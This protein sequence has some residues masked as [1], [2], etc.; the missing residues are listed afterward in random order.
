MRA[1]EA[2]RFQVAMEHVARAVALQ[3]DVG[4]ARGLVV[5]LGSLFSFR[6]AALDYPGAEALEP[7]IETLLEETGLLRAQAVFEFDRARRRMETG[8]ADAAERGF[9]EGRRRLDRLGDPYGHEPRIYVGALWANHDRFDEAIALVSAAMADDPYTVARSMRGTFRLEQGDADGAV[10]DIE[11]TGLPEL[12]GN[13]LRARF[14]GARAAALARIGQVAEGRA[15]L[16]ACVRDGAHDAQTATLLQLYDID[17]AM[18]ELDDARTEAHRSALTALMDRAGLGP[19][20]TVGAML[21]RRGGRR[22]ASAVREPP[23]DR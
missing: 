12:R 22:A 20:S 4:S 10:A 17:V 19:R 18:A 8:D 15:L 1:Y 3:R 5:H 14:G 11:V 2:G 23:E 13:P 9:Y 16:D 6:M 7:E 21:G